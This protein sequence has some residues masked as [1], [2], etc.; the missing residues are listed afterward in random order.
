MPF[1]TTGLDQAL[2]ALNGGTFTSIIG[3]ASLH[4]AYS[5]S[6][7]NELTGG[8]PAYARE[9][10]TW[11][12]ASGASKTTASVAGTFNV[13]S[14]GTVAFVGLWAGTGASTFAGMG[15]NGGATQYGFTSVSGTPATF[16][17]PSSSYSANQTVVLFDSAG[18]TISTDF[19][20]GQIYYVVSPSGDTFQLSATSGGSGIGTS[21]LGAGIVQGVTVETYG[22]QGTFSLTSD[23]LTM[24]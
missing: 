18:A 14:S 9:A 22:S 21:H 17:A 24:I 2:D 16:T 6:G 7:A 10:V 13:P 5:S 3:Y 23:T 20:L 15:P 8:S 4:T 1:S 19:T 12:A 11:N